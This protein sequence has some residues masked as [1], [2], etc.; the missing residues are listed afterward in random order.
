[1]ED[2]ISNPNIEIVQ[3]L[4]AADFAYYARARYWLNGE[5]VCLSL[6]ADP[7]S[8][9]KAK[10]E[11]ENSLGAK[12][13]QL[14]PF[15]RMHSQF[16]ELVARYF[17]DRFASD[18]SPRFWIDWLREMKLPC[19]SELVEAVETYGGPVVDWKQRAEQAEAELETSLQRVADLEKAIVDT[20]LNQTGTTRQRE[21]LLRVLIGIALEQYGYDPKKAR[22]SAPKQISDDL[23]LHGLSVSDDTIRKYLNEASELLSS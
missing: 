13:R 22:N 14:A 18:R 17:N 19:P 12:Q 6:G 21:T 10:R 7:R 8:V 9:E 23:A 16:S 1:M 5:A 11:L 4:Y 15:F 3:P 2:S 20:S